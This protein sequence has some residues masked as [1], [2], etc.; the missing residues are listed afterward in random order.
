MTLA[1]RLSLAITVLLLFPLSTRAAEAP[2]IELTVLGYPKEVPAASSFYVRVKLANTGTVPVRGCVVELGRIV[3][4]EPCLTLGYRFWRAPRR[5]GVPSVDTLQV[6][7]RREVLSPG[8]TVERAVRLVSSRQ[9][10][11]GAIHLY[12]ISGRLD[13]L[14]WVHATLPITVGAA[15]FEVRRREVVTQAL[16]ALYVLGIGWALAHLIMGIRAGRRH[17]C[18]S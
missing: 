2:R 8:Q 4:K 5:L 13:E 17:P 9:I 14:A 16:F 3:S 6:L 12:A 11:Q 10:D 18:S 7:S 15:P 1:A